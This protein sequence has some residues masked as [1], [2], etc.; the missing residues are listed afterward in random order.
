MIKSN[1]QIRVKEVDLAPIILKITKTK[2]VNNMKNI[3][4]QIENNPKG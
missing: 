4:V 3:K 2:M 1:W